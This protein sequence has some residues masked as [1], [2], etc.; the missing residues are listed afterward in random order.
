MLGNDEQ[1]SMEPGQEQGSEVCMNINELHFICEQIESMNKI[2][3]VDVLRILRCDDKV[4]LNENK[5]GIHV[6]ISDL[7]NTT[8]TKIKE[9]IHY[10]NQQELSF[11]Q[12]EQQKE[13]FKNT[14][15]A[16]KESKDI[17]VK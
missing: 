5:N 3:H 10:V 9:Y 4:I 16:T 2:N 1:M 17:A 7:S 6:N 12:M 13:S 8:I 11:E 15:F 14:Y